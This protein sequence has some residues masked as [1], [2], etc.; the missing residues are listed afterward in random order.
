MRLQV[1]AMQ[2]KSGDVDAAAEQYRRVLEAQ[3]SS[4]LAN[5]G[6][7]MLLYDKGANEEAR[8]HAEAAYRQA[9]ENPAV[10]D[11]LGVIL[12]ADQEL[13]RALPLLRKANQLAPDQ[14]EIALHL[15]DAL[16]QSGDKSGAKEVLKQLLAKFGEFE[17]RRAL[18]K[19]YNELGGS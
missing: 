6:L 5:N 1:A 15:S 10:L 16:E 8:K 2:R 19:R 9:E 12:L 17:G 7:A 14:P 13:D 11:T 3:P 4:W 18:Q